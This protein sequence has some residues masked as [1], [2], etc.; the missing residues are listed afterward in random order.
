MSPSVLLPL[1]ATEGSQPAKTAV[2][3]D[4]VV[5]VVN[6]QAILASDLQD[7]MQLAILDPNQAASSTPSTA[8]ILDQL[9]SRT[10]IEQQIRQD[11]ASALDPTQEEVD[12]RIAQIRN[13]LPAC[14]RLHCASDDKWKAFLAAHNLTSAGVETYMRHR[15]RILS[16][17]EL[18]FRQGISISL[19]DVETYYRDKLLPQYGAGEAIPLLEQVAPRIQ[20]ILLQQQVNMLFDDWLKSLRQQGEV[21]I[22]DPSLEMPQNAEAKGSNKEGS[23]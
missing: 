21:E 18:R 19:Q 14:V 20:E 5:A 1:Q 6:N 22:L 23:E 10:L 9:I 13:Q 8:Q 16:F 12:A 3:I 15:L 17:I 4:R 2:V 7:E 11:E